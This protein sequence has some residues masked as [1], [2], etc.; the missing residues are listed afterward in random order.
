M[1]RFYSFLS[2]AIFALQILLLFLV[3]FESKIN[4][5]PL[6]QTFGRMH[7]LLLHLPIGLLVLL[8]LLPLLRKEIPTDPFQRIQRFVLYFTA[9]SAVVTALFG[10]FLAQEGGYGVDLL[11]KHKWTGI[12]LS[13]LTYGLL[14]LHQYRP[15][16][17]NWLNG[18]LVIGALLMIVVGHLGANLTHGTDYLFEPLKKDKPIA[19]TDQSTVFEVAIEPI[20]KA[21]CF[22]CHNEQ[23]SKGALIMT[24]LEDLAKGGENGPIWLEGDA[25]NS[26]LIQRANLPLDH[27]E[28]MP[29]EGKPQL[30]AIEIQIL[31][32]WIESGA[33]TGQ[34]LGELPQKDSLYNLVMT[35]LER[36]ALANQKTAPKYDFKPASSKVIESLN[37]PYRSVYPATSKSPALHANI[38]VRQTYEPSLLEELSAVKAQLVSLNLTNM[39]IQDND[40][41]TIAQFSNLEELILNGTDISGNTLNELRKNKKL[42]SLALSNTQ[43][44]P[45]IGEMLAGFPAL[46]EVFLWNTKFTTEALD[47]LQ[48]ALPHLNIHQG[49]VPDPEEKLPLSPPILKNQKT[50]L[51]KGEKAELKHSFPGIDIRY[52]T[53]GEEPDSLESPIYGEPIEIGSYT[54]IKAKA[55]QEGWLT[56]KLAEFHL[57][58]AGIPVD[59]VQLIYKPHKNYPGNG[60]STLTDSRKGTAS[61]FREGGAWLGYQDTP[62]EAV[63]FMENTDTP[64]KRI[65]LSYLQNMGP[66]IMPPVFIEVWGGN[67]PSGMQLLKKEIPKPPTGYQPNEVK[68]ISVDFQDSNF[69]CYKVVAERVTSMPSWHNAAGEKGW[70]FVDEVLFY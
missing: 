29:P 43:V 41:S 45:D 27:E 65:V 55:F 28:H 6:V 57:F 21:K 49:F 62:F 47:E 16:K 17:Q 63:F 22:N 31:S 44:G 4:L 52:T 58:Q 46:E 66:Y 39:P 67:D 34:T 68:A 23:K 11:S 26:H 9:L 32:A 14:L 38:F 2:N 61:N 30:S 64:V 13:W 40:L 36:T 56:S 53:D 60:P 18:G 3:L 5:P 24:S 48:K 54:V 15:N 59:S 7:P 12:G 19:I 35:Q 42:R 51:A 1:K 37:N 20:L 33:Q 10:L 69:K 8:F 70:V 50:I 25:A